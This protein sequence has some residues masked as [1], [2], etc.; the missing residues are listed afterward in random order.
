MKNIKRNEVISMIA[1]LKAGTIYS[2]LFTKKDGSERL[3]N[4][5]KGTSKGVSGEGLR[6]DPSTKQLLPVYDLQ[7]AKAQPEAPEKAWRMVN[8]ATIK[9]L[10]CNRE[11]YIIAD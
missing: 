10:K 8:L 11:H 5:I 3:M 4:S 6:Y 9:E 7:A 2:V 1:N